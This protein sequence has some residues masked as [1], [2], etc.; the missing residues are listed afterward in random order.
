M[1]LKSCI[2]N[3]LQ[4]ISWL[5]IHGEM[6]AAAPQRT[7]SIIKVLSRLSECSLSYTVHDT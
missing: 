1:F 2:L 3:Y 5:A 4:I 6:G 7:S